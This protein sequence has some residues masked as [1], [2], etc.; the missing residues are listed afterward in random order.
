MESH[1][2]IGNWLLICFFLTGL[3]GCVPMITLST[4]VVLIC[5]NG[6]IQTFSIILVNKDDNKIL[7]LEGICSLGSV[8]C[9]Q[10]IIKRNDPNLIKVLLTTHT[11]KI[12]QSVEC[13]P[14]G[15]VFKKS[16]WYN[17]EAVF[18]NSKGRLA[19]FFRLH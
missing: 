3:T 18:Q 5:S 13:W 16:L 11:F 7:L 15:N 19:V 17:Y 12:E 4:I 1:P 8:S 10:Q 14:M 9:I 6:K 2:F